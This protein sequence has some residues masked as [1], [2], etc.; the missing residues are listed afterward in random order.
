MSSDGSVVAVG[1]SEMMADS[2]DS[3]GRN[4]SSE[5]GG[6]T[7]TTWRSDVHGTRKKPKDSSSRTLIEKPRLACISKLS[8]M[9]M[10]VGGQLG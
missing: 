5:N 4:W 7:P 2:N 6:L 9:E 8:R 3:F 1:N 10:L